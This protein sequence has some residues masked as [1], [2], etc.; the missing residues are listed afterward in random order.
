VGV[1]VEGIRVEFA[2]PGF[3]Q[4]AGL[5]SI[6][7]CRGN[8][9][10]KTNVARS[11]LESESE[12]ATLQS[13]V[14]G[15]YLDQVQAE[16][17]R[18]QEVERFTQSYAVEQF[19]FIAG[20]I[21]TNARQDKAITEVFKQF[22]MLMLE[23]DRDWHEVSINDLHKLDGFWTVESASMS[24]LVDL[25]KETTAKVTCK[26]VAEF[27]HFKGAP[28]PAGPLLTNSYLSS[29]PKS[30]VE[31]EFEI[32]ELRAS[33]DDRRIDAKWLSVREGAPLWINSRDIE[34]RVA[35]KF[36]E[37]LTNHRRRRDNRAGYASRRD[38]NV[39]L[40]IA[41][42]PEIGLEDYLAVYTMGFVRLLPRTPIAKFLRTLYEQSKFLPFLI[43][44]DALG[45]ALE[46]TGM[47]DFTKSE[48][49]YSLKD[50]T[51]RPGTV[52]EID[53][54]EFLQAVSET[55]NRLKIF[56]PWSWRRNES[57]DLG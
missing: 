45:P 39:Q 37:Y 19:P 29:M 27:A 12:Q 51:S 53:P 13:K 16:I 56:D 50:I 18:L 42:F 46:R 44:L 25:L 6:A 40:A 35:L 55:G 1:C 4:R 49:E 7:D 10:P 21:Y 17:K 2:S 26:Q 47:T 8:D 32:C 34:R 30:L 3:P 22:P 57:P 15:A 38:T 20:P 54:T 31:A 14:F 9:A 33:I 11:A 36:R 52:L 24:S 41:E 28:L 5:L 43:F 48:I 23:D